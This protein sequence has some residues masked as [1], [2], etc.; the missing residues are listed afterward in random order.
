[1]ESDE[2]KQPDIIASN[3]DEKQKDDKE[4]IPVQS[5]NSTPVLSSAKSALERLLSRTE[6]PIKQLRIRQSKFVLL[7]F[8]HQANYLFR[9]FTCTVV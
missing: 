8:I 4:N 3:T 1:M 7:Y 5:V 2:P 6:Q 9:L